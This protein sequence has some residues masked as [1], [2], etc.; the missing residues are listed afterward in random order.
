[1]LCTPTI[2]ACRSRAFTYPRDCVSSNWQCVSPAWS[3]STRQRAAEGPQDALHEGGGRVWWRALPG[4]RCAPGTHLVAEYC[5]VH[6]GSGQHAKVANSWSLSFTGLSAPLQVQA[7]AMPACSPPNHKRARRTANA[8]E[9]PYKAIQIPV[10][11]AAVALLPATN[12]CPPANLLPSARSSR[13]PGMR[14]WS[15]SR[16]C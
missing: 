7:R 6:L 2:L 4:S 13:R 15:C 3:L 14:R 8:N 1:M 12:L 9:Y 11:S 16:W 10:G 5:A